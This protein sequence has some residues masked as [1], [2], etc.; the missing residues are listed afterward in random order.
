MEF[1]VRPSLRD[2]TS[3][4][5]LLSRVKSSEIMDIDCDSD[6]TD[7]IYEVEKILDAKKK[8]S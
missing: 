3:A 8:V 6:S 1:S 5:L 2:S 7:D 4:K